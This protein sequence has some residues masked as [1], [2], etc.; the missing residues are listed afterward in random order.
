MKR[1][2]QR[3]LDFSGTH[4]TI[5]KEY[6]AKYRA[7]STFLEK[8]PEIVDLVHKD[9]ASPLARVNRR[10]GRGGRQHQFS[11]ENVL[12]ILLCQV[13]EGE[14]LR[15]I[16]VRIDDSHLLRRFVGVDYAAMMD[17]TTLCKLKN[18]IRPETWHEVNRLLA[19]RALKEELIEGTRLR[20][21]TT[22]VETN[23]HYPTDSSLLWDVYRV[24]A[25]LIVKLDEPR[26]PGPWLV[27][28][29]PPLQ[30]A[31]RQPL[32]A[33]ELPGGQAR[34]FEPTENAPPLDFGA[35][36]ARTTTRWHRLPSWFGSAHRPT[37]QMPTFYPN[38]GWIGR[39]PILDR[40]RLYGVL[41]RSLKTTNC[42]E[43]VNS[44]IEERCAKVDHWKNSSQRHR[45]LATALVE[46]E[47]R[48]RKVKGYRHLPKLREALLRELK[49]NKKTSKK[50]A[51]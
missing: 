9:L 22:A 35:A 18:A 41:G 38:R 49:I 39:T 24:L 29:T 7:I 36:L 44:L 14:S 33:A 20:V 46:I 6:Y 32:A 48:L 34:Q 26:L 8:S 37:R 3:A 40:L 1:Q 21:D 5:T 17:F 10:A 13:I 51:A 27:P 2:A 4:L 28:G 11:S 47:P 16:V 15:G 12:R 45:W 25:R 23:I 30:P 19:E 43:S 50:K 42:L 31:Q